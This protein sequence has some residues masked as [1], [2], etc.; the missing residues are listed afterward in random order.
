[1]TDQL[2]AD[3]AGDGLGYL[4]TWLEEDLDRQRI[5]AV[6]V[7]AQANILGEPLVLFDFHF[8][9]LSP[10]RV[11]YGHGMYLVAWNVHRSLW[12][13]R[14][15]GGG[16]RIDAEPVRLSGT[17]L[18]LQEFDLTTSPT[19]F[20]AVWKLESRE[21]IGAELTP[22]GPLAPHAVTIPIP[23]PPGYTSYQSAPHVAFNGESYLLAYTHSQSPP[24]F[25][26]DVSERTLLSRLDGDGMPSGQPVRVEK[27]IRDIVSGG[28]NFALL[29]FGAVSFVEPHTLTIFGSVPY[30]DD[31][32]HH[33]ALMWNGSSY[34][35]VWSAD[36]TNGRAGIYQRRIGRDGTAEDARLIGT[37][38][39]GPVFDFRAAA[40]LGDD[41][42]AV[43][44]RRPQEARF[45]GA[46]RVVIQGLDETTE[47]PVLFRRRA[48]RR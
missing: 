4:V 42:L 13:V 30:P 39:P 27:E 3:V 15:D 8:S 21:I 22:A 5:V 37:I 6:R 20:F 35:L 19:G 23:V 29:Q 47:Q 48:A 26:C 36:S 43:Y 24:C 45:N 33:A 34:R 7:D 12:G 28:G 44:S 18:A 1:M 17:S 31:S 2:Q 32:W 14:V 40:T 25:Q 41:L 38:G 11:V 10:P 16:R 46:A 9:F